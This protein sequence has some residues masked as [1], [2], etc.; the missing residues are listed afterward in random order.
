[1]RNLKNIKMY[2]IKIIDIKKFTKLQAC[3][4]ESYKKY[5]KLFLKVTKLQIKLFL[6]KLKIVTLNLNY[7][8]YIIV[9]YYQTSRFN[10]LKQKS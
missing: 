10:Y 1:M 3:H 7:F 4:T 9:Q 2:N 6:K 5:Q 8:C